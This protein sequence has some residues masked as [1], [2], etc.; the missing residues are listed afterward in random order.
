MFCSPAFLVYRFIRLNRYS[1]TAFETDPA[2]DV[3]ASDP[4]AR[5][6]YGTYPVTSCTIDFSRKVICSC[7]L[8]RSTI[9]WTSNYQ[10]LQAD[11]LRLVELNCSELSIP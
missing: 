5:I 6:L 8:I 9:V 10:P 3:L 2:D 11:E 4:M 7:C 1:V